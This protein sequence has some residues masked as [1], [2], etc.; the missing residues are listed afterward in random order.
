MRRALVFCLVLAA[1]GNAPQRGD[2]LTSVKALGTWPGALLGR[3]AELGPEVAGPSLAVTVPGLD[4]AAR[5]V[6]WYPSRNGQTWIAPGGQ[7]VTLQDG[8]LR[9]TRGF[10][11]DLMASQ[12]PGIA[13]IRSGTGS[14]HRVHDYLDGGD[15]A[16][17]VDFDCDLSAATQGG[18]RVVTETCRDGQT[19]FQNLYRFAPAGDLRDSVQLLA[20]GLSPMTIQAAGKT[21]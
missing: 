11:P 10:G 5:M 12:G 17:Q 15:R 16:L 8:L 1:C 9:Q 7:S 19:Q 14:F 18:L 6:P 13:Q 2:L 20:P 3:Q 4:F 21:Q